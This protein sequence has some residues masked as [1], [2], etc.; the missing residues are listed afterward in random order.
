MST[1]EDVSVAAAATKPEAP[2][3]M[4]PESDVVELPIGLFT[5]SGAITEAKVRELNGFDEEAIARAK[6][7][8]SV[9][10]TVLERAVVSLGGEKVESSLL[11]ELYL[12]DRLALLVGVSRCTWGSN[13]VATIACSEC[14]EVNLIDFDLNDLEITR[15][16][17]T[18]AYFDVELK[19]GKI[20]KVHW[21]RGDV[22]EALLTTQDVSSA[23][24]RSVIINKCVD[25]I[26][27]MPMFGDAAK[28]LSVPD[29]SK[30]VDAI[31]NIYL[32]PRF[33][34][35][36]ATCPDC[37]KEVSPAIAL[38]DLFPL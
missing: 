12:A 17:A 31:N 6:N 18:D 16:Q 26:D 19:S 35:T 10:L 11:K 30:I 25:D 36:T 3:V 22:H 27:G 24:F 8:G 9:L 15:A 4:A 21:P 37:G 7:F 5:P 38:A 14:G 13:V 2:A 32:G 29:R 28:R 20:A 1:Q 23:T 33:D 34:L